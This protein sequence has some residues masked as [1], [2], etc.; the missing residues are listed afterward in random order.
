MPNLILKI[1]SVN[2]TLMTIKAMII[3]FLL[4]IK[5]I[6]NRNEILDKKGHNS[7]IHFRK[8]MCNNLN[9]WILSVSIHMQDLVKIHSFELEIFGGNEILTKSWT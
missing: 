9:R 8:T 5:I 7:V 4:E 3:P 1:F 6:L 2:K